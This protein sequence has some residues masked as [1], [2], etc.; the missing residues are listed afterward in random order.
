MSPRSF[1][2]LSLLA[3][4]LSSGCSW[5]RPQVPNP[6]ADPAGYMAWMIQQSKKKPVILICA[7]FNDDQNQR[8]ESLLA[9][10]LKQEG[11]RI[12]ATRDVFHVRVTHSPMELYR[13]M[14]SAGI[15]GIMEVTF[16]GTVSREGVPENYTLQYREFK[17]KKKN[18]V[19][20]NYRS[21]KG[22]LIPLL[23]AMPMTKM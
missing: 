20:N 4:L 14:K 10:R 21:I 12:L 3:L 16:S 8:L 1:V 22:A 5:F 19:N 17:I 9:E 13:D 7:Q 18:I 2:R 15:R 6:G 23:L 11:F